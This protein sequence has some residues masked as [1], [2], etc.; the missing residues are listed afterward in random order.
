MCL[1]VHPGVGHVT[2]PLCVWI[3]KPE[4]NQEKMNTLYEEEVSW[5]DVA[6]VCVLSIYIF[7]VKA[8][9]CISSGMFYITVKR[10]GVQSGGRQWTYADL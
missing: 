9:L 10:K 1:G 3:G 8:T 4:I 6:F 7:K 2:V 5:V